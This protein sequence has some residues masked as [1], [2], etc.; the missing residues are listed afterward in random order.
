MNS[1]RGQ[2]T[3]RQFMKTSAGA[4]GALAMGAPAWA[5]DEKKPKKAEFS[6]VQHIVVVMM[7]N[8]SFDHMLGWLPGAT[9]RQAGLS[10]AD[11]TGVLHPTY[12][13]APDFQGCGLSDPDHS[14]QGGLVEYNN[15]ACDGWLRAGAND[16]F[17]IGYYQQADLA[18]LGQ[19]APA[20]TTCDQYFA[21][22]LA[23]TYPN[24]I[25]QHAAQTDRLVNTLDI[26]TLP[27][28]WDR[29]AEH[30]IQ[31]RY[32]FT[33]IPFLAL[34][35]VKYAGISR[36]APQF[37][38][39]C[40]AGTL[41]AVS[42]VDPS[43][44]GEETGVSNDD[45]PHSDI[46]NGEVF[47]NSVYEAVTSSPNWPNTLLIINF[48]EW[49][50]F[51][52]HVPPSR[53]SIPPADRAAGDNDGLRGF[54]VPALVISPWSK[55]AT[56]AHGLYDHT[57]ILKLIES[58]WGLR[59]LTVRDSSARNLAEVLDFTRPANLVA[60][61]ILV[62]PGPFGGPCPVPA[63]TSVA[64]AAAKPDPWVGLDAIAR[65]SGFPSPT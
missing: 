7:E 50:G 19:A 54:R 24:R 30:R 3:R 20:W 29:L 23:E 4:S 21:A 2:V 33:D 32:Y 35:G 5:K 44:Y 57:S 59:P 34:W 39:D 37:L 16:R 46:R 63:T 13:L 53:F 38:A 61:R 62:P 17:C 41:P 56:V 12:P 28:I 52:E 42:F 14:H 45:H 40:A 1:P 15:G 64:R 26:S 58:R 43:F 27:T 51:F 36:L 10:Y 31:G 11:A 55:R 25:Y 6:D 60:R 22:T 65:R 49:G 48:D 9:G 8:R 47:L 18:F